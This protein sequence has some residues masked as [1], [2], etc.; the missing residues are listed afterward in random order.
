MTND[1][2]EA[3]DLVAETTLAAYEGFDDLRDERAFLSWLFTIAGRLSRKRGIREKYHGEY[4]EEQV[5][6]MP[7][8]GTSP[9]VSADVALLHAALEKLP[10]EQREA[11][12]LFE[13][14]DT[15]R[16]KVTCNAR[17]EKTGT[18]SGSN[19]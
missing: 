8:A 16:R 2:E 7:D 1:R 18:A 14:A 9:E 19:R 10:P 11:V 5:R 17:T 4:H 6:R 12:I 13:I 3:R 15:L